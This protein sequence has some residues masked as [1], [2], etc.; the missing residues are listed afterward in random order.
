MATVITIRPP[1][2]RL[3]QRSAVTDCDSGLWST[4]GISALL[5]TLLDVHRTG[6][7]IDPLARDTVPHVRR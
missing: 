2:V 4:A 3:C 6:G 1:A 7:F 5:T